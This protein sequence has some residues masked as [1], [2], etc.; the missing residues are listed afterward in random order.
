MNGQT[1]LDCSWLLMSAEYIIA[2]KERGGYP[3]QK[4][5]EEYDFVC[6]ARWEK[7]RN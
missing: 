6:K 5:Y 3:D 1:E 7:C 2:Q 4:F